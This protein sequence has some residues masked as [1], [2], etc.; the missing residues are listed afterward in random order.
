MPLFC[1]RR[2][3]FSAEP[4]KVMA[5]PYIYSLSCSGAH[6]EETSFSYSASKKA[7]QNVPNTLGHQNLVQASPGAWREGGRRKISL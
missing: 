3:L 2:Q 6:T 1:R 7:F 4:T 5:E